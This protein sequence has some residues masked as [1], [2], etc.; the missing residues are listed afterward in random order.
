MLAK[1]YGDRI[2]SAK[3]EPDSV[4]VDRVTK[5]FENEPRKTR[6]PIPHPKTILRAAGRI[7]RKK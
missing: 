6:L 1:V 3:E 5:A 2:P 4:L 7:P